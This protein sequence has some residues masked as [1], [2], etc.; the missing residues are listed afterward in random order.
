MSGYRTNTVTLAAL[1]GIG[2]LGGCAQSAPPPAIAAVPFNPPAVSLGKL[3]ADEIQWYHVAFATGSRTIDAEG[4]DVVERIASMM[5]SSPMLVATVV[6]KA[7]TVG[8]DADNMR[9][10]RS[11]AHVVRQAL[12]A[13]GKVAPQRVET[14]WTG[15]RQPTEATPMNSADGANRV[16]DIGLH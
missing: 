9:L 3:P 4:R 1:L 13:T 11:R 15:Q 14:R 8:N 7:D 5:Q 2:L 12:L 6:G 10:S 16:V